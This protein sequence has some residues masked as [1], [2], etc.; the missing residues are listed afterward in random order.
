M[1]DN[2]YKVYILSDRKYNELRE[3]LDNDGG[4]LDF[5]TDADIGEQ[6]L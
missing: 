5:E 4:Q 1:D 6:Q 3:K 2:D